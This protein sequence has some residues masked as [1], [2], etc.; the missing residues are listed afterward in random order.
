[1]ENKIKLDNKT[2]NAFNEF[3]KVM[4]VSENENMEVYQNVDLY[5]IKTNEIL[6]SKIISKMKFNTVKDMIKLI[7]YDWFGDFKNEQEA[8]KYYELKKLKNI[9]TYRL[10]IENI[11]IEKIN[12]EKLLEL[13]DTSSIKKESLGYSVTN[14]LKVK[15]KDSNT[16]AILKIQ[17]LSSRTTLEEEY[18]RLKWL[19][20]RE[21]VPNVYYWNKIKNKMFLLMEFKQG[22]ESCD[23]DN[24]GFRVG[25]KLREIHNINIQNCKFMDNSVDN[26][27]KNCITNIDAVS[28]QINKILPGA[29]KEKVKEFLMKNK[30]KDRTLVHGDYS[31]PN[32]LIDGGKI[33]LIDFRDLS[34]STKY[35]DIYYAIKSFERNNKQNEIADFLNAYGLEK[36]EENYIKWMDIIDKSIYF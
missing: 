27:L 17:T 25:K 13:I 21:D 1:M 34:V 15:L 3:K 29:N 11:S 19:E 31:L 5:N 26:L 2:F 20:N 32:I 30:P 35:Y 22:I 10:K 24:I 7:P 12:D 8:I 28:P 9:Y 23:C 33:N 16:Y 6:K 14:I 4:L 36:L 18:K